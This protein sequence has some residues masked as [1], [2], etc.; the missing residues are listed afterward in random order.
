M[1]NL[2]ELSGDALRLVLLSQIS[3]LVVEAIFWSMNLLSH[4]KVVHDLCWWAIAYD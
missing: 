2:G 1:V 3:Q 4:H